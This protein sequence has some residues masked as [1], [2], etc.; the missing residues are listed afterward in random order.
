[1]PT[2]TEKAPEVETPSTDQ[3]DAASNS[4]PAPFV[5]DIVAE[6]PP[7]T[8]NGGGSYERDTEIKRFYAAL[9]AAPVGTKARFK[10]G[11]FSPNYGGDHAKTRFP[12]LKMS[13][14][15]TGVTMRP[16]KDGAEKEFKV[17][18]LYGEHIDPTATPA[19]AEGNGD[20]IV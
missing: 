13:A 12:G 1:M 2:K 15:Q 19:P 6:I 8:R 10:S 7:A 4:E 3:P 11:V 18:D 9:M 14:R 20:S 16:G 5:L 17:F